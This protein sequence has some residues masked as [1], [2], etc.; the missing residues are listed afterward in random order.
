MK[1]LLRVPPLEVGDIPR[2]LQTP[3]KWFS[4]PEKGSLKMFEESPGMAN[5]Q[6]VLANNPPLMKRWMGF[7][8]YLLNETSLGLR[9]REIIILR[10]AIVGGYDYEWGQHVQIAKRAC[11]F[12]DK[13]FGMI[14]NGPK[15]PSWGAREK[16]A[17]LMVDNL[18]EERSVSRDTWNEGLEH[19]TVQQMMDIVF[20][21]GNYNM[22]GSAINSFDVE[23]DDGLQPIPVY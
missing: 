23:L 7:A 8:H 20:T 3:S 9:D 18:M 17:L 22:L 19:Y 2:E 5:V 10:V 16:C 12:T 4:P 13:D 6:R 15:H 1:K 11:S 21:V 14:I